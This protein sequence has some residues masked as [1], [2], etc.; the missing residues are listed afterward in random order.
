MVVLCSA[1]SDSCDP[2]DCSPSGSSVHGISQ[3]K[4]WSWLPFP[5]PGD[6]PDQGIK[7]MSLVSPA[8]A[9]RFF[10]PGPS[11]KESRLNRKAEGEGIAGCCGS[12]TKDVEAL[13][14]RQV[15]SPDLDRR[16]SHKCCFLL[17]LF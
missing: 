5:S 6:L 13:I 3:Q 11:G 10:A 9:D 17:L 14:C 7:P 2:M 1:V 4:Y 15:R 8:L 12:I 16:S